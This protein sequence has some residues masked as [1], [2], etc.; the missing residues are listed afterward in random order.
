M[1]SGP[2]VG[3]VQKVLNQIYPLDPLEVDGWYGPQTERRVWQFQD[4]HNLIVDGIVGRQTWE[5]LT[6]V[7]RV[8]AKTEFTKHKIPG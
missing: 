5:K 4:D 2:D 8:V 3:T 6:C 1:L 7:H